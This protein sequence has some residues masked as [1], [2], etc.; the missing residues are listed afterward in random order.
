MKYLLKFE[1]TKRFEQAD[2]YLRLDEQYYTNPQ[3]YK[4]RLHDKSIH[5]DKPNKE[6]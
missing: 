3:Q 6:P 5:N 2:N 1:K 4:Q